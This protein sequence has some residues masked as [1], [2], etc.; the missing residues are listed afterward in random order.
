M[1]YHS[2]MFG[3]V[4][5]TLDDLNLW[6]DVV[7]ELKGATQARRNYYATHHDIANKIKLS[8]LDGSF[9]LLINK[10]ESELNYQNTALDIF[11]TIYT[12]DAIELKNLKCPDYFH[13]CNNPHCEIFIKRTSHEKHTKAY[14]RRKKYKRTN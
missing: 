3:D 14:A 7:P 8:K 2:D 1:C 13:A 10:Q 11:K 6:L 5:V 9:D 12:V 4:I